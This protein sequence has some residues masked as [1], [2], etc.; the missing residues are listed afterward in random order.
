MRFNRRVR[1]LAAVASLAAAAAPAA[2][3]TDIGEGG[4]S[5]P[6]AP[7]AQVATSY[8]HAGSSDGALI[9]LGAGGAIVLV[10]VGGSRV[11]SRRR[12]STGSAGNARVSE[13]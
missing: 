10:G 1:T 13:R 4:D 3:A 6:A 5:L 9:A 2:Y 8:H 7:Q 11:H 12:M